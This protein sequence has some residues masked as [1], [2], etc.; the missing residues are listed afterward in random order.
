MSTPPPHPKDALRTAIA[1]IEHMAAWISARNSNISYEGAITYS[2][3]SICE[4]MPGI[5]AALADEQET[6]EIGVRDGYESA[7]QDFDIATGG[8]GEFKGSTIPGGTVDVPA[9][10]ARVLDRFRMLDDDKT[11]CTE[12]VQII[13]ALRADEGDSVT[14]LCANPDFNGQPD[15]AIE[16][17]GAWTNWNNRRFAGDTILDC[18]REARETQVATEG[19]R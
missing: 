3:E 7:V 12:I 4:D 6:Y 10:K 11:R 5:K 19:K 9:M 18:L 17:N 16:C 2:F 14:I 15:Y 8:D 1:H 13:L